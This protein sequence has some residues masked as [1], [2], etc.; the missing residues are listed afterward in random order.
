MSPGAVVTTSIDKLGRSPCRS[1]CSS[2]GQPWP[3]DNSTCGATEI[4]PPV[5]LT[6]R[7]SS[8][9]KWQQWM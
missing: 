3:I 2:G 9:L 7:H 1:E 6:S 8:S 4:L 5:S